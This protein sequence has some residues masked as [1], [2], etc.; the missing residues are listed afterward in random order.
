ML[1]E[2]LPALSDIAVAKQSARGSLILFV[3]YFLATTINALA[4]IV[5]ARLLGPEGYGAYSL[6]LL[7]PGVLI[8]F[9]GLGVSIAITRYSAYYS[10]IGKPDEAKRFARS[11]ILF[12]LLFG[13][14]LSVLNYAFANLFSSALILRPG[15]AGY[16]QESSLYIL[17]ATLLS[18][19]TAAATGWN[20][21]GLA[22]ASQVLQSV[23]KLAVAPSL[24][25]AGFGVSGAIDGHVLSFLVAG[26]GGIAVLYL[27]KLRRLPIRPWNLAAE[28]GEMIRFGFPAFAGLLISGLAS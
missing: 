17:G 27:V 5:M 2:K 21:M 13:L 11:A 24:I 3:G 12:L 19:V 14:A 15:F 9:A 28:L 1:S 22:S 25:L 16:I 23:V 20:M 4:I 26:F 8:L 7:A 18:T 10:S 6:S